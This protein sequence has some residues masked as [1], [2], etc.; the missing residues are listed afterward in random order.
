ML[1]VLI[2]CFLI[3]NVYSQPT[4][5]SYSEIFKLL[6]EHRYQEAEAPLKKYLQDSRSPNPAAFVEL[7]NIYYQKAVENFISDDD[8][9]TVVLL[10]SAVYAYQKAFSLFNE[11][12]FKGNAD[13]YRSLF[14]E[15]KRD[16]KFGQVQNELDDRIKKINR[17]LNKLHR[18]ND[19]I[20]TVNMRKEG[21]Y[22]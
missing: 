1:R 10:D 20:A 13:L 6:K 14:K 11:K 2:L 22:T 3:Q 16:V 17:K 9:I 5:E 7:G 21:K 4:G 8:N 15:R 12:N 19:S 18:R